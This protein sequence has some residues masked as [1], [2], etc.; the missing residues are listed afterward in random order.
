MILM[1]SKGELSVI[2]NLKW[3]GCARSSVSGAGSQ[4]VRRYPLLSGLML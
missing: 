3:K 4:I 2:F 1:A